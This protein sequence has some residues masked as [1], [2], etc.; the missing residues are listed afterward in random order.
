M[1]QSHAE[2]YDT[3]SGSSSLITVNDA[4]ASGVGM[5]TI[6]KQKA[7]FGGHGTL[8]FPALNAWRSFSLP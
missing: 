8:I 3:S 1:R 5:R 2:K 7:L 4:T 6:D